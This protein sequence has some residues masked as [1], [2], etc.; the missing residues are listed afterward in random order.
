MP[1]LETL[2]I[3][4]SFSFPENDVHMP[5]MTN[6]TLP[7]LHW[8][9]FRGVSAYMEAFVCRITTPRLEKLGIMFFE[10]PTFSVSRLLQFMDTTNNL[11]FHGAIFEF[12]EDEVL[13]EVYPSAEVEVY[14]FSVNIPCI[15]LVQQLSSVAQIFNSLSQVFSSVEH[16]T[17]KRKGYSS[18]EE[19]NPHNSSQWGR[20]LRS[21]SNVKTLRVDDGLVKEL[22]CNL[23]LEYGGL[24]LELLPKLQELTYFRSSNAGDAFTSFIGARHN[25]G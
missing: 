20:L 12:L 15:G 3:A 21:F 6:V 19:R 13:A 18:S 9:E 22:T 14:A 5:I 24:P 8:F 11:R 23:R 16:L 2:V 10:Q 25:E 1:Q 7:N 4:F 17:L